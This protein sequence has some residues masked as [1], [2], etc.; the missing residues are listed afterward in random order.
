VPFPVAADE[1][2]LHERLLAGDPVAPVDVY[3]GFM[4]PISDA[5]QRDLRCTE[6]D[7]HDSGVD[8]ILGYLEAPARYDREKGRLSTYLMDIAKKRV[9]DRIRSRTA[10]GRRDDGYAAVVELHSA[11]PKEVMEA[12]VEAKE[13]WQKVEAE[14][15][16]ERDRE[17]VK[18][19]LA[20]E[21]STDALAAA[22]GLPALTPLEV[23]RQ[24]KQ[25][26]DRLLKVLERLGTRLTHDQDA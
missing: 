9:I 20:G 7:A 13:L 23:R 25:H 3:Q 24:V 12:Q 11:N 2:A 8:A 26:R 22:L 6:D 16:D 15:P 1:L 18:L 10:S 19:I 5:L 4:D 14:V 21:R 17:A